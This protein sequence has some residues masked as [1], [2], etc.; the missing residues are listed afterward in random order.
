MICIGLFV[1][2]YIDSEYLEK[3]DP[4]RLL[5]GMDYHG[6]ICGVTKN[7]NPNKKS[8]VDLPKAYYLPSGSAVCIESCPQE[9]DIE[10]FYCKYETEA[11][12]LA[13]TVAVRTVY[14]EIAANETKKKLHLY[15]TAMKQCMPQIETR[16]YLGYCRPALVTNN[17]SQQL[18]MD[19]DYNNVTNGTD[20]SLLQGQGT[21]GDFFDEAVADV[22]LSRYIILGFG[23]GIAML[24][25]F[26]Y[27]RLIQ[28]PGVLYLLVWSLIAL[29]FTGLLAGGYYMKETSIRWENEGL[30][31]SHEIKGLYCLS[32]VSYVASAL[33][34]VMI[35]SIRKRILLAIGCVKAASKALSAMPLMTIYPLFQVIC[36]FT[37]LIPW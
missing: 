34:F 35:C 11:F 14:G 27:L 20:I 8:D 23:M 28:T 37:F 30:K 17:I 31:D 2:G 4:N 15:Y 16:P 1:T 9:S 7:I 36:F 25:G 18:S 5:N 26:A 10:K 24:L 6:N 29:V 12:I 22:I 3:G 13:E 19:L 33:W 32:I 21:G